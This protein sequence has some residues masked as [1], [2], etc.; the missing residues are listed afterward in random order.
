M[1]AQAMTSV[2]HPDGRL[3]KPRGLLRRLRALRTNT[4]G[5]ALI[6]FAMVLPV[7]MVMSASGLELVNYAIAIKRIGEISGALADNASRMGNQSAINNIPIS[8]SE[9]NDLFIGADLQGNGLDL[10]TK[11][12]IIISSLQRNADDGQTI[13]WQR[14]FGA[15]D[16]DSAYG[17]EGFGATGTS[18]AGMGPPG[19]EI[20]AAENTAVMVVEVHYEY[21]RLFPIV[22]LP[23]TAINDVTAFNV[24]DD[25]DLG[26]P[27]NTESAVISTC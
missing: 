16:I 3:D 15:L 18:F 5:L 2:Q 25:R 27:Q 6:E 13:G 19:Q 9:I 7:L 12:R 1:K 11:G 4:S 23:L 21:E 8:E 22:D 10:A 20:T 14:C 24:R 26:A 17:P